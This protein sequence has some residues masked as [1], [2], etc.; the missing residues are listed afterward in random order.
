MEIPGFELLDKLG[1]GGMA[2]VW[3][4]RQISL[5][6]TVAIK[7]LSPHFA[8]DKSDIERFQFEAQSA[9][10]LKHPGIV[11]IHDANIHE[12]AYYFVMEYVAGYSIGDWIRRK[13][14]ISE[15]DSLLACEHVAAALNYA[16]ENQRIVHCDIKPDNIMID[17]DGTIKVADLGLARSIGAVGAGG[18]SDE[19]M[20][21]PN[22][23]SPEQISGQAD[24]DCR[25]DI[26]SLAA[27]LY[28][29]VTGYMLFQQTDDSLIMEKQLTGR[30][31]DAIELN[32]KLSAS[33]CW[34]LEKM[35]AKDQNDRH[36]DWNAVLADI[37]RVKKKMPLLGE[38][39]PTG[40]STISRSKKRPKLQTKYQVLPTEEEQK[41]ASSPARMIILGLVV[42]AAL[43]S[44][45][46]IGIQSQPPVP[47]EA[48]EEPPTPITV[49]P[50]VVSSPVDD[51]E[52]MFEDADNYSK[53]YPHDYSRAIQQF[54]N[55][56][57]DTKGTEYPAMAARRIAELEKAREEAVQTVMVTL[58]QKADTLLE[59]N[60]FE[61]AIAL[62]SGY[63]GRFQEES[64]PARK[65]QEAE[66]RALA[67]EFLLAQKN[68]RL[69][70]VGKEKMG[71][72]IDDVASELVATD[73]N[74]AGAMVTKALEDP[75]MEFV[76]DELRAL[77]HL[78]TKAKELDQVVLNSFRKQKGKT[79]SVLLPA[80]EKTLKITGI[81]NGRII[82]EEKVIKNA[83]RITKTVQLEVA[84]LSSREV[85]RRLGSGTQ[86]G[87][88]LKKGV[89]AVQSKAYSYAKKYFA[90]TD[91]MLA[92]KLVAK[93]VELESR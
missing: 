17:S 40:L 42:A 70:E 39:L 34:L 28:Q 44:L 43:A 87:M 63:S 86:I 58:K 83:R 81:K 72:L 3:K 36:P 52:R 62:Y 19:I 45:I 25:A 85:L 5:D 93:V 79:I 69:A 48:P 59:S 55:L 27:M 47:Q 75:D 8:H 54:E 60:K 2:T 71:K 6:R 80:E 67:D 90:Q 92:D 23:M 20:G 78:L 65:K 73:I 74:A 11:Q 21:T 31:Q 56:V 53:Q 51:A 50:D 32:S 12:G 10:K 38:E 49:E 33:I 30:V 88:A 46:I 41:K 57:R 61:P 24:L 91:E 37:T 66:I 7:I 16:W 13:K 84:H 29:M 4:A 77:D 9:A 1:E 82:A 89:L 64:E 26:Y 22:Y 18:E 76:Q 15:A 68:M 14:T 35:L